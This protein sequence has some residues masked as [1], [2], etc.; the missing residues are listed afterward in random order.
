LA[1]LERRD[2]SEAALGE[3][4]AA[5]GIGAEGARATLA[6][7]TAVGLVD[8]VRLAMRRAEA[9][10]AR[11]YGDALIER[12]LEHEGLGPAAIREALAQLVPEWRRACSVALERRGAGETRLASFLARRGFAEDS[13]E[14][15]LARLDA[16]ELR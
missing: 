3:R 13:V 7:L 4:L 14:T 10:V 1:A 5:A 15:A 2:L 16:P 12:R 9:L 6:A 11:G 8:D